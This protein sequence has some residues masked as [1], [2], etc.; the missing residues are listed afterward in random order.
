MDEDMK[1]VKIISGN[2]QVCVYGN[3]EM[4]Q[5]WIR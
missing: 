1:M 3:Y 2:I 5:V 4:Y